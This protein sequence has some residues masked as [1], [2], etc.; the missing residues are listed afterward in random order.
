MAA[1]IGDVME[2]S[3]T[4]GAIGDPNNRPFEC[5]HKVACSCGRNCHGTTVVHKGEVTQVYYFAD[6][7]TEVDVVC[8]DG[9]TRRKM[10][11]APHGDVCF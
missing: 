8:E 1:A 11:V 3:E 10:I 6:N 4:T 7:S 2:V 9:K 5:R